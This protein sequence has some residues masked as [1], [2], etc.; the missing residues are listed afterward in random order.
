MKK[1]A[2]PFS[3]LSIDRGLA[4][5]DRFGIYPSCFTVATNISHFGPASRIFRVRNKDEAVYKLT[6]LPE[7]SIFKGVPI[8]TLPTRPVPRVC[9]PKPDV[10]AAGDP[11]V[12]HFISLLCIYNPTGP[13]FYVS[14]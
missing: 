10:L 4:P 3:I 13:V 1:P 11:Y 8:S 7:T 5:L 9:E 14:R 12:S 2:W 6:T